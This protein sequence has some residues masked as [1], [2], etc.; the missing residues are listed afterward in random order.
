VQA[1]LCALAL[2]LP[3][4][5]PE[6]FVQQAVGQVRRS[7]TMPVS[8]V[9]PGMRGY[10]LTVFR[11]T[12]PERFEVEVI[13]V[14]HQ[15][16]PDQDL[17]LVRTTH[18][19]LTDATTVGGMSGSPIYLEDRLV[20]AYA[21]GWP[22][23]R[24]PVAGVTPIENMMRELRRTP[25]PGSFPGAV[26]LAALGAPGAP[27]STR[28]SD[29]RGRVGR[30]LPTGVRPYLGTTARSAFAAF[31]ERARDRVPLGDGVSLVPASTPLLVAGL[32]PEVLGLLQSRLAPF[33]IDV[34]QAGGAGLAAP[35]SGPPP[36]FVDGGA[37]AVTLARGDVASTVVGT[38]THVEGNRL[39][40]F[41]HPMVEAGET[42][43]PTAVARVLH[44]LA[45]FQRS[46]KIAEPLAPL[47][48]M[49]QDRQAA[50]VVDTT[51]QPA[52]I[53]VHLRITGVPTEQR[54]D[55]RFEVASH[56]AITPLV[57]GTAI[58]SAVK[59]VASDNEYVMFEARSR[60]RLDG[61]AQPIELVD[62]GF[63]ATGASQASALGQIRAF[64]VIEAAY[65][66][67]FRETR[68]LDVDVEIALRF[69]RDTAEIVDA[70]VEQTEVNPGEP[71]EVRVVLRRWSGDEEVRRFRVSIPE[72][73][74][75][76][77]VQILIQPGSDVE[78]ERPEPRGLD[79]VIEAV[80]HRYGASELVLSTRLPGRGLRTPGH[81]VH[82]VPPS[83]LDALQSTTDSDRVRAFQTH[84]RRAFSTDLVL[85]GASRVELSVRRVAR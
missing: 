80:R 42:G 15:F 57:L 63:T 5:L 54:T 28:A 27:P 26:P 24:H 34:L 83:V 8:E 55:W 65:A 67:P 82:S 39:V 36:R 31:D 38:V 56:R 68:V 50:V 60:V 78:I 32:H 33:G 64:D 84:V 48:T 7:A 16:R 71:V 23:G 47:G 73:A 10:G 40:A 2:A 81:V 45:S 53:P 35:A 52:M 62:R 44:V 6:A 3:L 46:F 85:T 76:Q 4:G 51:L 69:A 1:L 66:N 25:R 11:G 74:A 22:F 13:D 59:A 29:E 77:P 21:Y 70:S 37:L 72:S 75:G 41:G 20:G 9:R 79:D 17:I 12:Q 30:V 18:P 58:Q 14:L 61:V 49:I 19:I 43:F